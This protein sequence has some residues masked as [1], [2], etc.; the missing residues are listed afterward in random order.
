M[1]KYLMGTVTAVMLI[2]TLFMPVYANSGPVYWQGYPA[3]E[4]MSVEP[5]TPITV[6]SEELVFDFSQQGHISY[7]LEGRVTAT[8]Q[9]F[10]PTDEAQIVQMAFPFVG[11]LARLNTDEIMIAAEQEKIPYELY[12][13]EQFQ[14]A[15]FSPA[16]EE[17]MAF[18]FSRIVDALTTQIYQAQNFA[19]NEQGK[20]Y[21][22][23]VTPTTEQE[24]NFVLDF[25]FDPQQTK[26]LT[27]GFNR[28]ERDSAKTRIAAWCRQQ[29]QLEVL[30]LCKDIEF[31][32]TAYTDGELGKQTKLYHEQKLVQTVKL[33]QYL[34]SFIQDKIPMQDKGL[35]AANQLYN[36]YAQFL[37]QIFTQNSGYCSENDL[38]AA[39]NADR[40][41]TLVYTVD[42]LPQE[43]KEVSISYQT[44]GTMDKRETTSPQYSYTY[45]LN[46]ASHWKDFKNLNIKVIT[47][48]EA[49]YVINSSLELKQT[50]ERVYTAKLP[51]LPNG[52]FSF[53]LFA[54]ER[55][56]A[57]DKIAGK[58]NRAFGYFTPLLLGVLSL[59]MVIFLLVFIKKRKQK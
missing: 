38:Y 13:G 34:L 39:S 26:I 42:F 49:P 36:L 20:L 52:D 56:T 11:T 46:P 29:T 4:M 22:F 44:V 43:I 1:K 9:M 40:I 17:K 19:D 50:E 47:P 57:A 53:T 27:K 15:R 58:V 10:N 54:K 6:E 35:F 23:T 25:S 55:I 59:I 16:G 33:K 21:F 30:V 45:L 7:A 37:D 32:S 41:M 18:A 14:Q 31:E 8:Y 24:I 48:Q 3:A 51:D 2:L 5:D 28:Y 12:L